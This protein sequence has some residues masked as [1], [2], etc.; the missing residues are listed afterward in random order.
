M[1]EDLLSITQVTE[2]PMAQ[3]G[4]AGT[5]AFL[6]QLGCHLPRC[7]SLEAPGPEGQGGNN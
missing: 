7:R 5:A 6:H 1:W 3:Q 2:R 4:C